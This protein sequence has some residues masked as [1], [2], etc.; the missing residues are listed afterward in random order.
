[1]NVTVFGMMTTLWQ[2]NG[3]TIGLDEGLKEGLIDGALEGV[4]DMVGAEVGVSERGSELHVGRKEA[5]QA[6]YTQAG[7]AKKGPDPNVIPAQLSMITILSLIQIW[8][9]LE[10]IDFTLLGI[11]TEV[12]D[13]HPENARKPIDVTLLGI[14]TDVKMLQR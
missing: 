1:M 6:G 12:R 2:G 14:V 4:M 5:A 13:S 10:L 7:V 8:N 11:L 9:A 3:L